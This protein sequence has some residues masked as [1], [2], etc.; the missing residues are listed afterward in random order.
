MS[1]LH[2]YVA[3]SRK[4]GDSS[5]LSGSSQCSSESSASLTNLSS[6]SVSE[7]SSDTPTSSPGPSRSSTPYSSMPKVQQRCLPAIFS[8]QQS[9]KRKF[10]SLNGFYC[11][12]YN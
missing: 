1:N 2:K 6:G 8:E 4:G 3:I 5:Q 12:L 11:N 7:E 9:Y 10:L